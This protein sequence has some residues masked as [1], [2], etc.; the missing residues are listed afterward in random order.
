MAVT[1]DAIVI[2]TGGMGSSALLHLA[3]RGV[4]VLGIDQFRPPHDRGSSHGETRIIR[5]AYFEHPDYVLLLRRAYTL[6]EELEQFSG[7]SLLHRVGLMMAGAPESEGV[8]GTLRAA[9]EHHLPLDVLTVE[10][11]R[12]RFP[13]YHYEDHWT[14]L[15]E[16]V[17]GYLTVERCVAAHLQQALQHG[18]Q[19]LTDTPVRSWKSRAGKSAAGTIEVQT[20]TETHVAPVVVITAGA[21]AGQLLGELGCPLRPVRKTLHWFAAS[22]AKWDVSAGNPTFFFD[23]P[24]G[25][26][27][28][29]PRLDGATI[30]VAEHT[31]GE[32]V[33]DPSQLDRQIQDAD[34]AGVQSFLQRYLPGTG[35]TPVRSSVCMYTFSPDGHFVI[36]R[37]PQIP[38]V[39][40]GAGFSGHGC[41][42][43]TVIGEVLADLAL[44][45]QTA[46]P[47]EFLR[48]NR[49][50]TSTRKVTETAN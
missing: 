34:Y 42:F 31:R 2:G 18:A 47:I 43:A 1:W 45:G 28:G 46:L 44:Q 35:T 12:R 41:K 4:R 22:D 30:K 32:S 39:V 20:D 8:T 49:W 29:F 33:P 27:Y 21:W 13:A 23:L 38:G 26:F 48:L 14:T 9:R 16:P 25:Q 6:W 37:H 7:E 36:D 17:A 3:R 5:Q 11:A 15:F 19:L 24:E 10:E 50:G 40:L